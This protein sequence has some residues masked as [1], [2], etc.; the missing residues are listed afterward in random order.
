MYNSVSTYTPDMYT[1]S[2][3]S[4]LVSAPFPDVENFCFPH[5]SYRPDLDL[6]SSSE[7]EEPDEN[8]I[9]VR[10]KRAR[11][12]YMKEVL[13]NWSKRP[14]CQPE[15]RAARNAKLREAGRACKAAECPRDRCYELAVRIVMDFHIC[16]AMGDKH[17]SNSECIDDNYDELLS[18]EQ[19]KQLYSDRPSY[20][21]PE[22]LAVKR[23]VELVRLDLWETEQTL[24]DRQR[25]Y[26]RRIREAEGHLRDHR[27]MQEGWLRNKK[28]ERKEGDPDTRAMD[29]E[30]TILLN[31]NKL[32]AIKETILLRNADHFARIRGEKPIFTFPGITVDGIGLDVICHEP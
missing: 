8:D 19:G 5:S 17:A 9:A 4:S 3:W 14:S 31:R 25:L 23:Q 32:A 22:Y 12:A 13:D 28:S 10:V 26:E 7:E 2:M 30:A 24:L 6:S 27:M 16:R 20:A 18:I 15:A 29:L 21:K 1:R 11:Q